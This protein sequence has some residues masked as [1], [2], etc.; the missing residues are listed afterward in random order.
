MADKNEKAFSRKDFVKMSG[1]LCTMIPV[2]GL[3][4][5]TKKKTDILVKIVEIK[6]HCPVYK[7]N[8]SFRL[9]NGYKLVSDKPVCMHALASLMPVY[10]AIRIAEPGSRLLG[11]GGIKDRNK[12]YVQC[13]DPL[14][15]TGGGTTVFEISRDEYE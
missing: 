1:A 9:V 11:L 13:L 2:M 6:G 5:N 10:N 12:A 14:N 7:V 3:S 8:D 4:E 15:H